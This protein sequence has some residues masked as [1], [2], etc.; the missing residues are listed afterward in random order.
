MA[1]RMRLKRAGAGVGLVL[2]LAPLAACSWTSQVATPTFATPAAFPGDEGVDPQSIADLPWWRY[3]GDPQ[4]V[5]MIETGLANNQNLAVATEIASRA[6]VMVN[7]RI[8]LET[9]SAQLASSEE[10]QHCYL[11]IGRAARSL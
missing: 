11:G 2:A 4:L 1:A 7:G 3:F 9:T 6:L 5:G 8:A 10:L